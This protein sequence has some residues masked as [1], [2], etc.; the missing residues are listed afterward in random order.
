MK[1]FEALLTVLVRTRPY[2]IGQV[3]IEGY[4]EGDRGKH[5]ISPHKYKI[6]VFQMFQ[7]I[8]LIL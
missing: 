2:Y 6:I 8:V 3:G 7:N 1:T 4:E 5:N